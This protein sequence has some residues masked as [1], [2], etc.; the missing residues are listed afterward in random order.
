MAPVAQRGQMTCPRSHS[1]YVLEL[2]LEPGI[3]AP[4]LPNFDHSSTHRDDDLVFEGL[5][6]K[7][8][9]ADGY[10]EGGARM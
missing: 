5:K 9:G 6:V 1:W 10:G 7:G 4:E 2:E 8:W 3:L